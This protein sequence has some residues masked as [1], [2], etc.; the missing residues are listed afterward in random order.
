MPRW[1]QVLCKL[2][3]DAEAAGLL[4]DHLDEGMLFTLAQESPHGMS[5]DGIG[6]PGLSAFAKASV[7]QSVSLDTCT[8]RNALSVAFPRSYRWPFIL[9]FALAARFPSPS[10]NSAA[11]F[12]SL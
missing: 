3:E 1:K 5:R 8:C 10:V 9:A 12:D 2:G 4:R 7:V 6:M 11:A